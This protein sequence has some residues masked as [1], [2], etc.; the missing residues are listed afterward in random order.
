MTWR[1]RLSRGAAACWVVVAGHAAGAQGRTAAL[2]LE[3]PASSRSLALGGAAAALSQADA[4]IFS[5]PAQLVSSFRTSASLSVQ[6]HLQTSTLAALSL[7]SRAGRGTAG[8]GVQIL[9]YGSEA[10]IVPD[11]AF[12]GTRGMATGG[13]VSASDLAVSAGYGVSLWRVRVGGAAKL[14]QQRIAGMSGSTGAMDVGIAADGP[15]GLTFGG[16]VQNIGDALALAGERAPLPRTVRAGGA[17]TL[18]RGGP[19]AVLVTGDVFQVRGSRA[20]VVSGAEGIWS[21]RDG[22]ALAARVG[23]QTRPDGSAA[24]RLTIGGGVSGRHLGLDYAFQGYET[25]GAGAH[26][27]GARWWR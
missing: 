3:M 17:L 12:G 20:R 18:G 26:R 2:V 9:D 23:F 6:R 19:V 15:L 22:V 8:V 25:V 7:S 10:E 21:T 24:S 13:Q 4:S 11:P 16:S 5:N 14:V 1:W 27:V